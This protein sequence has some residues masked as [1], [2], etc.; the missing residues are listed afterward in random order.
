MY[1]LDETQVFLFS[2]ALHNPDRFFQGYC[3]SGVDYVYGDGG[4][5]KLYR[6]TGRKIEA[7]EDG[8]YVKVERQDRRYFFATDFSGN[9]KLFYFSDRGFWAVSNSIVALVE[10]MRQVGRDV[11]PNFSQISAI[12]RGAGSAMNQ[13]ASYSTMV[14]GIFL[15]PLKCGLL[16]G[17]DGVSVVPLRN[18]DL[19]GENRSSSY[20]GRL[21]YFLALWVARFQTILSDESICINSDLTGGLDSRVVFSILHAARLRSNAP[22]ANVR[23]SC[24]VV[25]GDTS[26]LEVATAIG[27]Q[28]GVVIN[29]PRMKN[30]CRL[31]GEASYHSWRQLCLGVYHPIYFPGAGPSSKRISFGGGGGENYRPFYKDDSVEAFVKKR[32]S[33]IH[34]EWLQPQFEAEMKWGLDRME[35]VDESV[36]DPMIRHYRHFRNRLHA[37]RAPQ[38]AVSFSPLGSRL[39]ESASRL[40]PE[41]GLVTGQISYDVIHSIMPELLDVPFDDPSK[42][43]SCQ[44]LSELT[45]VVLPEAVPA[46]RVFVDDAETPQPRAD[47]RSQLSLLQDEFRARSKSRLNQNFWGAKFLKN[48]EAVLDEAVER[49]RFRHAVDGQP[50]SAVLAT[51]LF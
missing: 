17:P 5:E 23:I 22:V 38:Y 39:L 29:G 45:K 49:R 27:K 34:P 30:P 26:D 48:S 9:K 42:N 8:C 28:F 50:I 43:P 3:F 18:E 35:E 6:D 2:S 14:Q 16:I 47:G 32:V 15:V 11:V 4:A 13:L 21:S 20:A 1:L 44:V 24:G 12:G 41:G 37:G 25:L 40:A 36:S 33:R 10:H 46:G 19:L 51:G 7:G 31:S